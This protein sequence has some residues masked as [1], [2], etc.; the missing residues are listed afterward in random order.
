MS[1]NDIFKE[2]E[3]LKNILKTPEIDNALAFTALQHQANGKP[4]EAK[5]YFDLREQIAELLKK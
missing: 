2:I 1:T 3:F 5:K 4:A